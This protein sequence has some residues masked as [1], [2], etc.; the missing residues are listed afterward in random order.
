MTYKPNVYEKTPIGDME[1]SILELLFKNNDLFKELKLT[2]EMFFD[3][4][5][6]KIIEYADEQ[7]K[8]D[9]NDIVAESK[10][11]KNFVSH[12]FLHNML[13]RDNDFVYNFSRYQYALLDNYKAYKINEVI[14]KMQKIQSQKDIDYLAK[15]LEHYKGLT[16]EETDRT[17]QIGDEALTKLYDENPDSDVIKTGYRNLDNMIKGFKLKTMTIIGANPSVGKTAFSLNLMWNILK[18][19]Y[20]VTFFSLEMPGVD[21]FSRLAS[22]IK[23]IPSRKIRDKN[24]TT[25]EIESVSQVYSALRNHKYFHVNDNSNIT[26]RDIRNSASIESDKPKII[27][28]D[29]L[30]FIKPINEKVD[31]R[32]QIADISRQ[33]TTI[34]KEYNVAIVCL[35]QL[36]RSNKQRQDK[37]PEMSDLQE[38]GN[39]EQD[40]HTILMIHRDDYHD[41]EQMNNEKSET[42]II[43][44]KNR[45]GN[46]GSVTMTF[47]KG[48]Q[49]F[50]EDY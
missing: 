47:H 22:R 17:T 13:Y 16:I 26:T 43:V 36:S 28:I 39:I 21:M 20:D 27:F 1:Y 34:A 24:L 5:I 50:Y 38:S 15:Q 9:T 12:Q 46:R 42:K 4:N 35:A 33:L 8:F 23:S 31:K 18:N 32:I 6:R 45:E 11:N 41:I 37:R 49:T 19:G 29:H 40:A 30:T 2:S 10:T 7:N 48:V 14:Q 44:A 25:E 3:E